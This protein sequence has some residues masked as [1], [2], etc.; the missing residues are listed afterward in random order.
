MT[1]LEPLHPIKESVPSNYVDGRLKYLEPEID[2]I[3][4]YLSRAKAVQEKLRSL[5]FEKRVRILDRVGRVWAKKLE[6]GSF[7]ALKKELVKSTGYSEA[8]IEEDLRLVSE[9]FKKE[10]VESLINSGLNG[11]V[12]SLDDFVEVAPGEYVSNLPAGPVFII[13][14]GNSVIPPLIPTVTSLITNN[15]TILRPSLTNYVVVREVFKSLEDLD[16]EALVLGDALL[17]TY[18]SHDS[19]VLGYL[20]KE[21]PLGVIN[22]WGGEPG[23]T[24]VYRAV[25]EN[26]YKPKLIVNGPLTGVAVI[27]G[28]SL[29]SS[30]SE[31]SEAL[32]R[33]VLMYDQQ[34]CSSPTMALF[35]G[36]YEKAVQLAR[37][38][39]KYLDVMG[40]SHKIEVSE[41]WLYK[42][43][44]LRKSLEFQGAKVFKSSNPENPYTIV[45]S[46][47]KSSFSGLRLVPL[48][49]HSRRRFLELV[50]VSDLRECVRLIR[51]LPKVA[52][53]SGVDKVQTVAFWVDREKVDSYVKELVST[54]VYRVVPLGESF[55]R[56]PNEPYDGEYIPR[57]FTYT[58]YLRVKKSI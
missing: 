48:E 42:L 24:A 49:F 23:R 56:T 5:G 12:K 3:R 1:N 32:A 44:T 26:P 46:E 30:L 10:N 6:S 21:A 9:V 35:V 39:S 4:E 57:Y 16:D 37:E 28:D 22:Y 34:L 41:G 33:E 7:E 38:V 11:G 45:V 13:A 19:K 31:V 50:V 29:G 58:V 51:E 47:G 36:S 27:D 43:N 2:W 53:Y 25:A 20:L 18:L 17:I 15:L 14:S 55:L 8:M 54:G 40:G 52:G